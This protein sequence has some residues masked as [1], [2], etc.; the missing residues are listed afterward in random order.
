MTKHIGIHPIS[1][2]VHHE[3]ASRVARYS[4]RSVLDVGGKGRMAVFLPEGCQLTNANK[5]A[6]VDGT[7]LPY[8]D[9]SFDVVVSVATL[10]HVGDQQLFLDECFRV[11]RLAVVHWFP[12]GSSAELLERFK[13]SI[14]GYSHPSKV[15]DVQGVEPFYRFSEHLLLMAALKPKQFNTQRVYDFIRKHGD[16]Y[17]G[18]ILE[19]R[20]ATILSETQEQRDEELSRYSGRPPRE[21]VSLRIGHPDSIALH[22]D[23]ECTADSYD[24]IYS[25]YPLVK[26]HTHLLRTLAAYTV[27]RRAHYM[28][29]LDQRVGVWKGLRVLDFGCGVG[30]HGIFCAQQGAQ[31]DLLD[32]KGPL[33]EYAEWRVRQRGLDAAFLDHT[34][35]LEND[36]YD[37]VICLDVLEHVA[38]PVADLRRILRALK[39][40]GLLALEVSSMV[41][42]TSGHFARTIQ[43][44]AKQSLPVLKGSFSN[45]GGGIWRKL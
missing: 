36:V 9:S 7:N 4:P 5:N 11:A 2:F 26:D 28:R 37:V 44:W 31:V 27:T 14:P 38:D 12:H 35:E 22:T 41:K 10:E 21:L 1:A 42:P 23:E 3:V 18:G 17:Y 25:S 43:R 40:G 45:E 16:L 15:P 13:K 34:N 6:G 32:V 19:K 29:D 24:F 30:S 20:K 39:P 8:P 33:R